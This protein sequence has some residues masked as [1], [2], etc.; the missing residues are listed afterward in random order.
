MHTVEENVYSECEKH[1]IEHKFCVEFLV[2]G[3]LKPIIAWYVLT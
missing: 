2:L 1:P 3:F